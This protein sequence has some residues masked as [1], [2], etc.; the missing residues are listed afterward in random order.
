[1]D[2][3]LYKVGKQDV[4]IAILFFITSIFILISLINKK[5]SEEELKIYSIFSL[6][7]YQLKVSGVI[8]SFL[9]LIY[10]F[11]YFKSKNHNVNKK[12]KILALFFLLF[13]LWTVKT[14]FQT[15]CLVFPLA[16]TCFSSLSWV[17][18]NT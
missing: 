5:Y 9:Y 15:G 7:L 16:R 6:F 1:M 13:V 10:I 4:P 2:L 14:L 18:K 17:N 12:I 3:Y 8:I 11:Y